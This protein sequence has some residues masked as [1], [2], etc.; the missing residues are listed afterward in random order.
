MLVVDDSSVKHCQLLG[1]QVL[2]AENGLAAF[3]EALKSIYMDLM[4][5]VYPSTTECVRDA[6]PL[7]WLSRA[8]VYTSACFL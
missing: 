4:M 2:T 3:V 5:F 1:I 7:T 6:L 8:C